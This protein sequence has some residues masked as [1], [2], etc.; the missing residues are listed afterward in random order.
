VYP[1]PI[2]GT[3]LNTHTP[4]IW[5][6][7]QIGNGGIN[8][9]ESATAGFQ[10]PWAMSAF[11]GNIANLVRPDEANNG[12]NLGYTGYLVSAGTVHIKDDVYI[13]DKWY[14][15]EWKVKGKLDYPDEKLSWSFRIGGKFNANPNVADVIYIGVRRSNL[16]FRYSFLDWLKNADLDLQVQFSQDGGRVIR[17]ELEFGKK[18]PF[19]EW[20]FSLTL[21]MGFVWDSPYEYSG[22]LRTTNSSQTTLV[23]RPSIEF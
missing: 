13:S 19:P 15:V 8:V 7:G 9:F 6:A 23:F 21:D 16:D 11:F 12:T 18:Y 14:E 1:L 22:P 3:Y 4:R 2:L 20:G 17:E 5:N 10:E